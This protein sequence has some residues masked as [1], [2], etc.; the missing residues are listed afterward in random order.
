MI[1][2]YQ[3]FEIWA[4]CLKINASLQSLEEGQG[5]GKPNQ[6]KSPGCVTT[7]FDRFFQKI[8]I[9]I[10]ILFKNETDGCI[11]Q[12]KINNMHLENK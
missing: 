6:W 7:K 5:W 10:K 1:S 11:V 9:L 2:S 12:N 3:D 8:N 4:L